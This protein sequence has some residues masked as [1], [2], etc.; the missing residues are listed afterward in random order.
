MILPVALDRYQYHI[1]PTLYCLG[2]AL[3]I[4][5]IANAKLLAPRKNEKDNNLLLK[6]AL[7]VFVESVV[8]LR[9]YEHFY[10]PINKYYRTF[11]TLFLFVL[12]MKL[13]PGS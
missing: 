4:A 3:L 8:A 2:V 1:W 6:K 13:E 7:I 10:R 11:H 5:K 12:T 9:L